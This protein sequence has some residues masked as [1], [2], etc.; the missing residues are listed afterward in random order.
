MAKTQIPSQVQVALWAKAGGRCEY[1]GC[2]EDLIGDLIAGR[3]DGKFGFTAHIVADSPDGP[4]GDPI[5][6]PLLA[7]DLSNLMLLCAKHHKAV[8]VDYLADHPEDVLLEMKT[9]HEERIAVVTGIARARRPR[10]S[11]RC[12]YCQERRTHLGAF[13]LFSYAARPPSRRRSDNRYRVS[14]LRLRRSRNDLLDGPAGE[15]NA[16]VCTEGKGTH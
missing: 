13:N 2:N 1:R 5:R 7:K 11:I 16:G 15:F 3:E 9:E 4:R 6:S 10:H 8:D 14:W 12:G